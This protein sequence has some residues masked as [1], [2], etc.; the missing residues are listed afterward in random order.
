MCHTKQDYASDLSD[1]EW[2]LIERYVAYQGW[3]RRMRLDARLVV[4]A[5]FYVLRTGCGWA[6]LPTCYPK[7]QSV[8]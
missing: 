4:N 6:Y 1:A 5:I 8:Y 7:W 2:A 3:G